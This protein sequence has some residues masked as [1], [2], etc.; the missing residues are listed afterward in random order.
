MKKHW[1]ESTHP[2]LLECLRG[3]LVALLVDMLDVSC[4]SDSR[5]GFRTLIC[6]DNQYFFVRFQLSFYKD[7]FAD[8]VIYLV[9][10]SLYMIEVHYV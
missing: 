9:G 3:S 2:Y 4:I 7:F 8:A 10:R 1:L 6:R 5:G